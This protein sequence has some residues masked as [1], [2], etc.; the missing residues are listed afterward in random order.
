MVL[1]AAGRYS[2][3]KQV[4]LATIKLDPNNA[5][6]LNNL[7]FLMAENNG[8]LDQALTMAQRAKQLLPNLP[9]VS[10]TLGSIYLRKNLN[11]DAVDI[12][13]NLVTKVPTSST[14]HYHLGEGLFSRRRQAAGCEPTANG[15]EVQPGC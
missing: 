10:D 14:Y 13:K 11:G 1:D 6:S 4:Y 15:T 5:I 3:A 7:A 9:E 8:D 12:F 2:E